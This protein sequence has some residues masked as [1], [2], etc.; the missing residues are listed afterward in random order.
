MSK[1]AAVYIRMSTDKQEDS[2]ERQRGTTKQAIEREG[3]RFHREYIDEARR[4]WDDTRPAF[5]QLLA[6]A[7]ARKFD[8]IVVDEC[9]RLSRDEP[10]DFFIEVAGPLKKAGV[11]LYS[12]A[13]GGFQDWNNL[14]GVLLSAVYQ[15]RSSGESKK[16]GYRVTSEYLKRAGQGSIDL[17]KPPYGYK[18]VWVDSSGRVVHEGTYPP[19]DVCRISPTPRLVPGDPAEVSVVQFIFDSYA[20]RDMS[21]R[22]IGR[23]LERRSILTPAGKRVW[24]QNCVGRILREMKYAGYYVFNR[25]RQGKFYRLGTEGVEEAGGFG[26]ETGLNPREAWRVIPNHHE[27]LISPETFARVQ[28]LLSANKTRTTPAPNRGDF[29]LTKL[30]FCGSCGGPMCGHRNGP[31]KPA[32]YRCQRA[33]ATAQNHCQHNLV[34][35]SEVLDS[36]L[37]ALEKQFLDPRFL[38]LCVREAQK[39]DDEA[40]DSRRVNALRAELT[41]LDRDIDRARSRLAKV[42][43]EEFEFLNGQIAGWK[44][45]KKE[46]ETELRQAGTPC[47]KKRTEELLR[48]LEGEIR[49]LRVAIQS[50]DRQCIRATIRRIVGFVNVGVECRLVGK[51]KNRYFLVGGD[52]VVE[53]GTGKSASRLAQSRRGQGEEGVKYV[54]TCG[55]RE[56]NGEA[57]E[58]VSLSASGPTACPR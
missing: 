37:A 49:R 54:S 38:D 2:P 51:V 35:E 53:D 4:G 23:E 8:I 34:K 1:L 50:K 26:T 39:L 11:R 24:S 33:M 20:N 44:A 43:D 58:T 14:P 48:W 41:A 27:P 21:L 31:G 3:F 5:R 29:L 10:I 17:G 16:I 19:E 36:I 7:Q 46:V 47:Q 28:E 56:D 55:V 18:R 25:V 30:L 15:D 22:D 13:E 40:T 32:F 12:V 45:R 9:S 42:D 57:G 6:D 52:I